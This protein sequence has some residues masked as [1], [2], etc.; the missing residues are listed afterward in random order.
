MKKACK[1]NN[2]IVRR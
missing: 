2:F 1:T